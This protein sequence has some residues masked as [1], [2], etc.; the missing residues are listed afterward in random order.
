MN[1][2]GAYCAVHAS[3]PV[4][5]WA[6]R[7]SL[8]LSQSAVRGGALAVAKGKALDTVQRALQFVRLVAAQAEAVTGQVQWLSVGKGTQPGL[9]LD[10]GQALAV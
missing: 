8:E 4:G 5:L 3:E 2:S 1:E 7:L 6:F 10:G 9:Y